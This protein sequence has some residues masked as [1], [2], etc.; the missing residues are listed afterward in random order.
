MTLAGPR[1]G[2]RRSGYVSPIRRTCTARSANCAY[3]L[4][5][6][7]GFPAPVR[8]EPEPGE[9]P[10]P[11]L[12]V[13][14]QDPPGRVARRAAGKVDHTVGILEHRCPLLHEGHGAPPRPGRSR[15]RGD[16]SGCRGCYRTRGCT[17]PPAGILPHVAGMFPVQLGVAPGGVSYPA[18]N[19][20]GGMRVGNTDAE[21]LEFAPARHTLGRGT[22]ARR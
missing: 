6:Q 11:V 13:V 10:V 20:A 8:E 12:G 7:G 14:C 19:M 3:D 17:L 2:R 4:A 21:T 5:P 1:S 16:V 22:G 9:F 18:G 15:T